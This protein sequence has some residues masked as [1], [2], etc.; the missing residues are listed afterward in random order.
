[1]GREVGGI[2]GRGLQASIMMGRGRG[3]EAAH[4]RSENRDAVATWVDLV[5]D[6][7]RIST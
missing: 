4:L 7:V 1:M 3:S 2:C 5:R 6:A